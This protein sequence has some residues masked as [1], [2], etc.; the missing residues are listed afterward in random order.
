MIN[1][2]TYH[3]FRWYNS[4]DDIESDLITYLW[5]FDIILNGHPS[6]V[7]KNAVTGQTFTPAQTSHTWNYNGQNIESTRLQFNMQVNV[8][9]YMIVDGSYFSN[10]FSRQECGAVLETSNSCEN[11]YHAWQ[12]SDDPILVSLYE[13]I[14]LEPLFSEESISIIGQ[15]GETKKTVKQKTVHRYKFVSGIGMVNML[16]GIKIN[17]TNSIDGQPIKNIAYEFEESENGDYATYTLSFEL[18]D[19]FDSASGCCEIINIDT[20]LSPENTGGNCTGFSADITESNGVLSVSLVSPPTGTPVYRWYKNGVYISGASTI[21]IDGAGDYR[22]DVKIGDCKASAYYYS[23]DVCQSFSI[24]LYLT[25]SDINGDLVNLPDG[26]T[27]TY[28]IVLN[29]VSLASSLP[30][31]ATQTGTYY[32]YV[33]TESCNKSKGIYVKVDNE[34]CNFT[35]SINENGNTLGAVT[36]AITPTYLWE[37]ET[38][39]GRAN[40][41][42]SATVTMSGKGIYWL[43]V[44]NGECVK[45]V[46]KY[47][48]PTAESLVCVLAR[49]TGYQFDVY[50][51]DLISIT[52]PAIELDVYVN[53]VR[54]IYNSSTPTGANQY[55]INGAGKLIFAQS[56]P[57]NNATIV[58]KNI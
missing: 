9:Y 12:P 13:A 47:K 39:D 57:L 8:K 24:N 19:V 2:G 46:Y 6:V 3:Y 31:T 10:I 38:K 45:T 20:I 42:T 49:S 44:T 34:D 1:L 48:E 21:T 16:N 40:I 52:N 22:V 54:S 50:E 11:I 58:I 36:D 26:E 5:S 30:Y 7:I 23:A 53:G 33:T 41:G 17:D 55:S 27:A 4:L 15:Y 51:I 29:G 35:V 56:L 43:T 25:G 37:L 32:V 14:Q 18:V 28:D